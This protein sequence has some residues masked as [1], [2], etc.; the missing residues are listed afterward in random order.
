MVSDNWFCGQHVVQKMPD[1][2]RTIA[3]LFQLTLLLA[4]Y[5]LP[6]RLLFR[7]NPQRSASDLRFV[8]EKLD[9][10][11]IKLGLALALRFD[12]LE[13]NYSLVFLQITIEV[14]AEG[15]PTISRT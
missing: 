3:R 12:L 1:I 11:F 14:S 7:S 13:T 9:L 4:R 2:F 8:F 15:Y 6:A 5:Q 10:T